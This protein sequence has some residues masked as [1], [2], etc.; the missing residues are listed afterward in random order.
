MFNN[1]NQLSIHH[2]CNWG[3]PEQA[4]QN[5][6]ARVFDRLTVSK[7][8]CCESGKSPTGSEVVCSII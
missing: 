8:L 1:E 3:E 5:S 4:P 2:N 7:N 6:S